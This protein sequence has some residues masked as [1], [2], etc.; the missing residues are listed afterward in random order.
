MIPKSKNTDTSCRDQTWT[1]KRKYAFLNKNAV[2]TCSSTTGTVRGTESNTRES[3]RRLVLIST[4]L[5]FYFKFQNFPR[6]SS[7]PDATVSSATMHG[8]RRRAWIT[9]DCS[10]WLS[11]TKSICMRLPGIEP[12]TSAWKA[13]ILPLNY[14]R[15]ERNLFLSS[16]FRIPYIKS[17]NWKKY[18][19]SSFNTI[20]RSKP[21]TGLL[22]PSKSA[23]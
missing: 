17:W 10:L 9:T 19:V 22:L 15:L 13:D 7:P 3:L 12:G 4:K 8:V 16:Y 20:N 5:V 2:T 21:K 18:L 14:K 23:N 11:R 6:K 1:K